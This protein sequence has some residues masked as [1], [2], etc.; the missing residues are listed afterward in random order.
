MGGKVILRRDRMWDFLEKF[1]NVV[2]FCICDFCGVNFKVFDGRGNYL[3]G[4]KEEII[5]LEIEFDKI[6]RIKGFDV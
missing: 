1:I 6:R 3:F 2:M 4:V 5:F